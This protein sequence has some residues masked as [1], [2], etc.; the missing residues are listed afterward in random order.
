MKL[1]RQ[2]EKLFYRDFHLAQARAVV[3][4]TGADFIE[5][6]ATVAY[7]EGGGQEADTGTIALDGGPLVR[8]AWA[9]KMYG[10]RAG[11]SG[12]EDVQVGGVIWHMVAHEDEAL[13]AHFAPGMSVTVSIDVER[14]A[15]LSL[16]HTASH[17]LYLAIAQHRPDA[18][19]AT[20]GC[21]IKTDG[22]RF[23]FAVGERFTP[24]QLALIEQTA[25]AYVSRDAPVSV[26]A[27]ALAQDA[28]LWHCEG[29]IIA[30]GGTHLDHAA[31]VGPMQ[32]RRHRLGA[33]KERIACTFPQATPEMHRYITDRP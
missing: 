20:L 14:R 29:Q 15:R 12:F 25:N 4:K 33:G 22:A 10:Q 24:H 13:L 6:D 3:V 28:R 19:A 16:S 18:V 1:E 30:C 32:L 31:P 11:I 27:H 17:F 23:D 8:F 21:H 5:L 9:K 7:P 26:T 2:T